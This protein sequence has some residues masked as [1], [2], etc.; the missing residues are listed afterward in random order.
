MRAAI[1]DREPD[2]NAQIVNSY[3]YAASL[4]SSV[5]SNGYLG[6]V[7]TIPQMYRF[8]YA[9][10]ER[11]TDV[12][13]FRTWIHQFTATN[14]RA[15][16]E[17]TKPDVVVCTHA[18]PCG[19]MSEYKNQFADSP[20]VVGVV[21]DF[22]VHSF[23]IHTNIEGYA[24]A[25][26]DMRQTLIARGVRPERIIVSG[27]PVNA[28][29]I[30]PP[31]DRQAL[32]DELGIP[33]DR[34]ALL[35]MGG[36][37]GIGPLEMMLKALGT[38]QEPLSATVI[39]GRNTRLQERIM[40]VAQRVDY[41]IRVLSFVDN[42]YDY[43]HASD[44]LLTKPGGLTSAEALVSGI[45]MVLVKPLPGQEER[46]T[47]YLVERKAALRGKNERDLARKVSTFLRTPER[48][49]TMLAAIAQLAKP[50]AAED[51]ANLTI[52][53]ARAQHERNDDAALV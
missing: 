52:N 36:G 6:M 9:R 39:V 22:A 45:P 20:P 11:A 49:S 32:R 42:V 12:G 40:Q 43:M 51:I 31:A 7:K 26:E 2:T 44:L 17:R 53:I 8:I 30:A 21:T 29:F 10:A 14:L 3:K 47:R 35:L 5:V 1:V 38:V 18:F 15:L 41:P 50:N 4:V 23:W 46:N 25:T 13:P 28:N 34:A 24:V 19:V 16:L 48:R 27:I 33:K 37:L